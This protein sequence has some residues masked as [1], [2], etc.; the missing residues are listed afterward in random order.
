MKRDDEQPTE[1]PTD[2][3]FWFK[4]GFVGGFCARVPAKTEVSIGRTN[5]ERALGFVVT[6]DGASLDFVLDKD[7]VAELAAYLQMMHPRLLKPLGRK[8]Q[9]ISLAATQRHVR[10]PRRKRAPA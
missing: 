10:R 3:E 6:R 7:Q 4:D 9:Q 2:L 1:Q 8:P 5:S